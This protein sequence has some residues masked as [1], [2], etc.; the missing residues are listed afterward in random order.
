MDINRENM[1]G[2]FRSYNTAF[3]QGQQRGPSIPTEMQAEYMF[4]SDLAMIVQS[5]GAE[6]VHAWLNQLPGF[7]RWTG[8]RSKKNISTDKLTVVN[9]DWEDTVAVL[10][11]DVLFD[12]YGIYTPVFA[13]L[14]YEGSDNALWLDAA[15]DALLANGQWA[16][17]KAFF[18]ANRVYGKQTVNNIV[19]AALSRTT[20]EA[21]LA[22]MM[23][24]KGPEG[25]PLS[26]LPVYLLV[27]P[28]GRDAAWDLVKN[29]LALT[30]TATAGAAIQNRTLGRAQLRVHPRIQGSQWFLLGVKGAIKPVAVQKAKE[31]VLIAKDKADDDN[32]FFNK[33][34][35][36]GADAIG[37]AFLT[38]PHLAIGGNLG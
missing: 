6:E 10:R 32:V 37:E 38:L 3:T 14:G 20:L 31:A 26:V 23:S 33:E 36:Y 35:I 7:R 17:G 1:S 28:N 8:D 13:N 24:F 27:G 18:A 11:N 22:T 12:K 16:D 15:V 29:T 5:T 9:A 19:A 4:L 21:A 30:G 25:N 34:F 2:L